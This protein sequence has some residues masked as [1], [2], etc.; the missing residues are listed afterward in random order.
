MSQENQTV[1]YKKDF[2]FSKHWSAIYSAHC[3]ISFD[4]DKRANMYVK[5]YSEELDQD[6]K[7]LGEK[8]GNYAEKYERHFMDW[9]HAKGRCMSSMITGPANFPVDRAEKANRSENNKHEAFRHWRSKYFKAVNRERTKSPEED[10]EIKMKELDQA[11]IMNEKIK[12][13]NK[14]IKK[15]FS[16]KITKDELFEQAE[17]L[18]LEEKTIKSVKQFIDEPWFCKIGTLG[19]EI[20]RKREMATAFKMRIARKASWEDIHF[21]NDKGKGRITIEDDRVK[22]YHDEKPAREVIT[23][24]KKSGFRWSRHWGCWCRK[25]TGNALWAAKHLVGVK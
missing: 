16:K 14:V 13:Y 15:Y 6:L 11:I 19:P 25:H 8:C 20:K 3:A 9:M 4:P 10:L 23:E 2:T 21:D 5:E 18:G 22:I 12:A 17:E 7:E 24:L 1:D